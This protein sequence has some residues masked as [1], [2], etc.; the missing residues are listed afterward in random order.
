[1]LD[2]TRIK[3]CEESYFKVENYLSLQTCAHPPKFV[4]GFSIWIFIF[5]FMVLYSDLPKQE[6]TVCVDICLF[7]TMYLVRQKMVHIKG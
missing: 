4:C 7:V 6:H 1:M 2:T 3:Y 5:R